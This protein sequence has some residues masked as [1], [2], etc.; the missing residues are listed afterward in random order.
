VFSLEDRD[1][2]NDHVLEIA[3]SDSR[4]VAGA[5]VGSLAFGGGDRWSDVDLTFAVADDSSL[6]EVLDDWT[7]R[8]IRDLDALVLFDLPSGE[9][10]YRVFF[11]P[12]GLQLDV[13]LTPSSAFGPG[14]PKFRLLFGETHT[15][16]HAA[17]PS[18]Q[19]LFGWAVA[20][21][22][23]A[24][25]C[26][27]R[28][29]FWQAERSIVAIRDNALTLACRRR[30][31][32]TRFGRGYDDLPPEV[33]ASFETSR[34]SALTRRELLDSLTAAVEG[35]LRESNEVGELARKAGSRLLELLAGAS[36]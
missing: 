24:R 22:R 29:R 21:A 19:E 1:A 2:V 33:L 7:G 36:D 4:V 35:L 12:G 9:T 13:S 23:D 11:L 17:P 3:R 16:P 32:P 8:L 28:R 31:L 30:D 26:I 25:A 6:T 15:T 34:V 10:I 20:Y 18:A 14:G 5:A 27:E